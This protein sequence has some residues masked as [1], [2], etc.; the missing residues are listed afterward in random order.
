MPQQP[1]FP[2]LAKVDILKTPMLCDHPLYTKLKHLNSSFISNRICP[3]AVTFASLVGRMTSLEE[4]VL[5]DFRIRDLSKVVHIHTP[6]LLKS[7][8]T[9]GIKPSSLTL[10]SCL[11]SSLSLGILAHMEDNEL[12]NADREVMD[13]S[14]ARHAGSRAFP[15]THILRLKNFDPTS[16]EC[17]HAPWPVERASPWREGQLGPLHPFIFVACGARTTNDRPLLPSAAHLENI[18]SAAIEIERLIATAPLLRLLRH[19]SQMHTLRLVKHSFARLAASFHL[20]ELTADELSFL[21]ALRRIAICFDVS[22]DE[23]DRSV[24]LK[25]F[26]PFLQWLARCTAGQFKS[27]GSRII[28]LKGSI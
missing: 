4:L 25:A 15:M 13:R 3:T 2:K 22:S 7:L 18:T 14:F 24:A 27:R 11:F 16:P 8:Q 21:P 23:N 9:L 28:Q 6:P 17:H 12:C 26:S 10:L 1:L 20:G 19:S 5:N